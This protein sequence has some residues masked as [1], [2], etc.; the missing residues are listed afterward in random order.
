ERALVMGDPGK[1]L[2]IQPSS[3]APFAAASEDWLN[4]SY[5]LPETGFELEKEM[6][7]LI[8]LAIRQ[9]NGN[10]S[11]AARLLGVPRDYLRY[12]LKKSESS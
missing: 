1:E 7:R 4:E 6:L 2:E 10:V 11:E 8:D 5:R 12:R 3:N 9:A